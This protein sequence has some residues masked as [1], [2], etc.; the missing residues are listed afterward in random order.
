[1]K[2]K[3]ASN[4]GDGEDAE[5]GGDEEGERVRDTGT[6]VCTALSCGNRMQRTERGIGG[7]TE[8]ENQRSRGGEGKTRRKIEIGRETEESDNR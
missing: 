4:R 5:G 1:M 8:R 3:K 7:D 6:T 2:K